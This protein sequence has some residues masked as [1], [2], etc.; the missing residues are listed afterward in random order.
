M[1]IEKLI[2]KNET[3]ICYSKGGGDTTLFF[4]HGNSSSSQ[5]FEKQLESELSEQFRLVAVDLPGHG[6]SDYA[7]EP[8]KSYGFA[9]LADIIA[10]V[11][12]SM[13][14]EN[15][16][17]IGHSLGGHI[18]L[19]EGYRLPALAGIVV[20]GSTPFDLPPRFDLAFQ[21]NP[22]NEYFFSDCQDDNQ[23]A[24]WAGLML[25]HGI[26]V[27]GRIMLNLQTTDPLFRK[28]IGEFIK[29]GKLNRETTMAESLPVPLAVIHGRGDQLINPKYMSNLSMKNLWRGGVQ[30][31]YGG[32]CLQWESPESFNSLIVEYA[33][34]LS[35]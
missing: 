31:L 34:E 7:I 10:G 22:A 35:D 25:S 19:Q 12:V 3:V 17:Y 29:A 11:S 30:Y 6:A 20:F 26:K 5:L 32:H 23:F 4:I 2:I 16:I 1:N 27:P 18:L 13:K 14:L 9:G 8:E 28:K 21:K 15:V 33:D 24:K